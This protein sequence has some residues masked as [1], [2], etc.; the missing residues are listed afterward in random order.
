[1]KKV[2]LIA[3]FLTPSYLFSQV[4]I[5]KFFTTTFYNS[6][7]STG[8]LFY[9]NENYDS[10]LLIY[11]IPYYLNTG[12]FPKIDTPSNKSNATIFNINQ[13]LDLNMRLG[14]VF[15][16]LGDYSTSLSFLKD[17][18]NGYLDGKNEGMRNYYIGLILNKQHE[19]QESLLYF[20]LS[21]NYFK[22][23][24][25]DSSYTIGLIY[26]DIGNVYY[27][28]SNYT[29]A[30]EFY[31][32]S[33]EILV[34][35]NPVDYS[36]I[37]ILTNNIGSIYYRLGKDSLAI[38]S[39]KEAI[40]I[41]C[42]SKIDFFD[43]SMY[44]NNIGGIYLM[45]NEIDS[46]EKYFTASLK[47]RT[48]NLINNSLIVQ[49]LNQI[50]MLN[51][52]RFDY[53]KSLRLFQQALIYNSIGFKDSSV[54]SNPN[55]TQ[56][57]DY[58]TFGISLYYKA[59]IFNELFLAENSNPQIYWTATKNTF[60]LLFKY[61]GYLY[62]NQTIESNYKDVIAFNREVLNTAVDICFERQILSDDDLLNLFEKGRSIFLYQSVI[63]SNAKEF[64]NVP[65][66]LIAKE[67]DIRKEISYNNLKIQVAENEGLDINDSDEFSALV[68]RR[69][70][71]VKKLDSLVYFFETRYLNYYQLKYDF[72]TVR[73][74]SIQSLLGA[75]D[76]IIEY[77]ISDSIIYTL[78]ISKF[79]FH[80]YHQLIGNLFT[81][82][83]DHLKGIRFFDNATVHRTG[84][85]LYKK[86]IGPAEKML[87]KLKIDKLIIIPDHGLSSL[88]FETLIVNS[89]DLLDSP[90]Y[91]IIDYSIV[92]NFSASLWYKNKMRDKAKKKINNQGLLAIAPVFNNV[93]FNN[94]WGGSPLSYLPNSRE[95][96]SEISTLFKE[97][98]FEVCSLIDTSA[99]K[100]NFLDLAPKYSIIHLATHGF[101]NKDYPELSGILLYENKNIIHEY[102]PS[103][104]LCALYV[105]ETYNLS[106]SAN[107]VVLNACMTGAGREIIGEGLMTF[108]R[109]FFFSGAHNI[110]FTLG[111]ITDNHATKFIQSFYSYVFNGLS[112]D[113]ALRETKISFLRNKE[114]SLPI[115]WSNYLILGN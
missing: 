45:I 108:Y 92:Y 83:S 59:I 68:E 79:S 86:L 5:L 44:L 58:G 28:N 7:I 21:L 73:L 13:R 31:N 37:S 63:E 75:K 97:E 29:K 30:L 81:T 47:I 41:Q 89:D 57:V 72:S 54:F 4:N 70:K 52:L 32:I 99:T 1:M 3:L 96:I 33:K 48:E 95:E 77:F 112:Y 64:A 104:G 26:C 9:A 20:F 78:V 42:I 39:Y 6:F 61:F 51:L 76:V 103:N 110:L 36:K 12:C 18:E 74:E 10:A 60:D 105:E 94:S 111:N 87:K 101:Y 27:N 80:V 109:G 35:Q 16:F 2:I 23:N 25:S 100:Q 50:A 17:T 93:K 106:I 102:L 55:I 114:T 71:C 15:Y 22:G 34:R 11:S 62:V 82:V 91:L 49:S 14:K 56:I 90:H 38:N 24:V 107:L 85:E 115:Y 67:N 88:P 53:Y 66:S 84:D 98:G 113:G 69:N 46:A 8:D 43:L 40:R 19:Y 65:D